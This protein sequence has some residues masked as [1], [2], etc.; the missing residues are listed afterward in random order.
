MPTKAVKKCTPI[1][2]T[3]DLT[4]NLNDLNNEI[5]SQPKKNSLTIT[6]KCLKQNF[7]EKQTQNNQILSKNKLK[8]FAKK[9]LHFSNKNYCNKKLKNESTLLFKNNLIN[10]NQQSNSLNSST[11]LSTPYAFCSFDTQHTNSLTI[12]STNKLKFST[13]YNEIKK[14]QCLHKVFRLNK[15]ISDSICNLAI[16]LTLN[17]NENYDYKKSI[18]LKKSISNYLIERKSI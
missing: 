5:I 6:D 14:E 8:N 2:S 13:S 12:N 7:I 4:K 11:I 16:K 9:V 18:T 3:K 10:V 17:D 15:T 1:I